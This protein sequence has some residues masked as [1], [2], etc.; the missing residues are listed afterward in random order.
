M[1]CFYFVCN[2]LCLIFVD[3]WKFN[4]NLFSFGKLS[5]SPLKIISYC[6]VTVFIFSFFAW[7]LLRTLMSKSIFVSCSKS[8]FYF[9]LL[10]FAKISDGH[11]LLYGEGSMRLR[12]SHVCQVLGT[13]FD[14]LVSLQCFPSPLAWVIATKHSHQIHLK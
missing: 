6:H 7:Q 8:D 11:H 14:M 1:T 2:I 5:I 13:V 3:A 12:I 9:M 4:I 10:L